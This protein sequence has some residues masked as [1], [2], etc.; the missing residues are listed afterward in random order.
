MQHAKLLSTG[1]LLLLVVVVLKEL[2]TGV[3]TLMG[4]KGGRAFGG[5]GDSLCLAAPLLVSSFPSAMG[6]G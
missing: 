5:L 1:K 2:L 4:Q 3:G 6:S